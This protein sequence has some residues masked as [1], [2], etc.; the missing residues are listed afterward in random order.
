MGIKRGSKHL[1]MALV[2]ILIISNFYAIPYVAQAQT[3]IPLDTI[4]EDTLEPAGKNISDLNQSGIGITEVDNT[5]GQWQYKN[6]SGVWLSIVAPDPGKIV[7]LGS[8]VMIRFV[9]KK[10]WNGTVGIKHRDWLIPAESSG[11]PPNYVNVNETYTGKESAFGEFEETA[12]VK[13]LPVNDTPY[14][15]ESGGNDYLDFDGKGYVTLPDLDIYAN[16]LT[17][18]TWVNASSAPSWGRIFDTSH[19]PDNFNLHFTFE[20]NTGRIALEA[21]PQKGTRVK[22]YLVRT[23]ERLPLNQWVHVAAVYN[24]VEKKAYIYWNGILKGSGFMDLTDMA[25]AKAQNSNLPRAYNYIGEST[26]SQDA[27][28]TGA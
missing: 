24:H 18:E 2:V 11:N 6:N 15:S 25:K 21:L 17:I 4:L 26:W 5:N 7:V 1:I 16:S 27:N 13:V 9:P 28:Y 14:I 23:T 12:Q 19:G 3:S 20:G 10:D 22:A 8:G